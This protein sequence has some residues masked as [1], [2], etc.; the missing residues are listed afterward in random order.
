MDE[1][2]TTGGGT[3]TSSST[4]SS[5]TTTTTSYFETISNEILQASEDIVIRLEEGMNVLF[6]TGSS[7]E[8]DPSSSDGFATRYNEE[9]EEDVSPLH[10]I[11]DTVLGD[12]IKGQVRVD[13]GKEEKEI[14]RKDK[15]THT[16]F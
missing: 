2:G 15:T 16:L 8:N 7:K 4:T 6:G 12:I 5:T 3:T 1:S 14:D 9:D 13:C 10:N 11:A